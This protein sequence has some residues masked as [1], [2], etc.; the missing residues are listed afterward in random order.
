MLDSYLPPV[1]FY[2]VCAPLCTAHFPHSWSSV[3][4]LK[5]TLVFLQCLWCITTKSC[6]TYPVKTIL[7]PH[8]LCP[9]NDA[10]WGLCWSKKNT[11]NDRFVFSCG[12]VDLILPFPQHHPWDSGVPGLVDPV[13]L[14]VWQQTYCAFTVFSSSVLDDAC[15]C[16]LVVLLW[17]PSLSCACWQWTSRR[18]LSAWPWLVELLS[19]PSW[20]ACSAAASVRTLGECVES[21]V[22]LL[23]AK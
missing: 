15:V 16:V 18:W 23:R 14:K 8:D 3:W 22:P 12:I 7:P 11:L 2:F 1:L 9:L 13:M 5:R 21:L 20:S 10:R 17:F 4:M 19:S 6:V